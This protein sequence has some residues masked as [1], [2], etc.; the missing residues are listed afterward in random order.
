MRCDAVGAGCGLRLLHLDGGKGRLRYDRLGLRRFGLA[1]GLSRL[2]L[3][4]GLLRR[5]FGGLLGRRCG[6][7]R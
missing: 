6:V 1:V 3:A 7:A 4:V 5:L 2:R